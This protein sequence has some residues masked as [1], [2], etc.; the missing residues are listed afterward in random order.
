LA[1]AA[2]ALAGCGADESSAPARPGSTTTIATTAAKPPPP[3][4]VP[5]RR[6]LIAAL[7]DSITA[8][9]PLWDPDPAMQGQM[10]E[11]LNPQ[12][13]Y[14]YWARRRLGPK[15]HFRNCGVGGETTAQVRRRLDACARGAQ[16]LI[17]QGGINDI[18]RGLPVAK[19]AA[20]LAAMVRRGRELGL[21]VAIADV[22]PWNN[23]YPS[24]DPAIRALNR[25]I[26][27]LARRQHVRLLRFHDTLED[28]ARP[29]RMREEWT[30]D[31]DHPSV[32]GYRLLGEVV[33]LP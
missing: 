20:N 19:A 4:V 28:P 26:H 23:G 9:A 25:R 1:L 5:L 17:V 10:P 6:T 27:A 15:A 3:V 13:Q 14:E 7:G 29:G 21:R 2:V 18:V 12:S 11:Q 24:A 8:G 22:L 30:I 16:V 32:I 33:V 31:G